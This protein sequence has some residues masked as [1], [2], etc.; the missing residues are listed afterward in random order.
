MV[1]SVMAV[2]A[3]TS[4]TSMWRF[5]AMGQRRRSLDACGSC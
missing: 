3:L 4:E 2:L 5:P 1:R